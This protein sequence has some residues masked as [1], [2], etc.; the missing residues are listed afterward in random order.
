M[1]VDARSREVMHV[2]SIPYDRSLFLY[3]FLD[4]FFSLSL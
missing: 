3:I 1:Y 4:Y 2:S